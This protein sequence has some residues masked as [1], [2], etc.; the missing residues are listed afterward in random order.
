MIEVDFH[1]SGDHARMVV[2]IH[3]HCDAHWTKMA[4]E[5]FR[6]QLTKLDK[7]FGAVA[8]TSLAQ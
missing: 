5:G 6:S 3:P 8:R 1:A 2:T 4:T 7:R